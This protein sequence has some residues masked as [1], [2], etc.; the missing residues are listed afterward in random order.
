MTRLIS[1][2]ILAAAVVAAILF[3]PNLGLLVLASVVAFLA[4]SEYR[5]IV[6]A[7]DN[8]AATITLVCI[9]VGGQFYGHAA[10]A[11]ALLFVGVGTAGTVLRGETLG[12][13]AAAFFGLMYIG[14]PLGLL[15]VIHQLGGRETVLLL[16]ATVVVSD[17]AQYYTGR[18]FGRHALAPAISPKKTIEGAVGGILFGTLFM[19]V[20]G[21]FVLPFA[22]KVALGVLGAVLVTLGIAG[23]LFESRL[24]RTANLKDS[25]TLIPGHGGI[26]DRIDALLFAVPA[27]YIFLNRW[28]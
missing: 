28:M 27:F 17:S 16:I 21:A 14:V 7:R 23:D 6:G 2:V 24:K 20:A 5:R 15:V 19:I 8:V 25:S 1:G 13:A 18:M 3:L 10:L 26:L 12:N 4:G 11:F 9:I 22:P